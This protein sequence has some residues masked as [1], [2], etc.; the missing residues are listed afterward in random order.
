MDRFSNPVTGVTTRCQMA[1]EHQMRDA[2]SGRQ[3]NLRPDSAA[4]R[5]EGHPNAPRL[6]DQDRL[7]GKREEVQ[8]Q[9]GSQGIPHAPRHRLRR[10]LCPCRAFNSD[11]SSISNCS[12]KRLGHHSH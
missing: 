11:Q 12:I 9:A 6:Q 1:G 7:G 5:N 8:V 2:R 10:V 3:G 4:E